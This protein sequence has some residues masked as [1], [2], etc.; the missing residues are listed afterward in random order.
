[1]YFLYSGARIACVGSTE[2]TG[3]LF[4]TK[5]MVQLPSTC[6]SSTCREKF[7][8]KYQNTIR[9]HH[10]RLNVDMVLDDT[11][12]SNIQMAFCAFS[13]IGSI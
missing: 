12:Q 10:H 2:L 8:M 7:L 13:S 9:K 1:M 3:D 11:V 4:S 6:H 5:N